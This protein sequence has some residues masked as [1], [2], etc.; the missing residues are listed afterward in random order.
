MDYNEVVAFMK[1]FKVDVLNRF[2]ELIFDVPTKTFVSID[3]CE[4]I[5]DVIYISVF[6]LCRPI[7]KELEEKD[8]NRI[9]SRMNAY[10]KTAL[11]RNDLLLMYEK[12]CYLEKEREF[13]AF[14]AKG[15]PMEELKN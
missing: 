6:A 5:E 3:Q 10:F 15:F 14:I 13:K 8:A 2:D 9:L 11:T 1:A 12:L 4:T 7:G